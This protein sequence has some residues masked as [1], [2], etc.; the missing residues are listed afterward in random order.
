SDCYE[1]K[2]TAVIVINEAYSRGGSLASDGTNYGDY[3]W[4]ELYNNSD[5]EGDLGDFMLYDKEDKSEFVILPKGTK[6]APHGFLVVEVDVEGGFG[7]SRD[8]DQ[9]YLENAEGIMIDHIVFGS[10]TPDQAYARNPD[11]SE[12]FG[13]QKPT[14]GATNN[15]QT[16]IQIG[17]YTGLIINE[18]DGNG[19]FVELYN[20]S[21]NPISLEGVMLIKDESSTWWIGGDI[22][23]AAHGFYTIAQ[24]GGA[25]GANEYT[26]ASG[27]STKKIVKFELK[28]PYGA[29]IIDFF[30]RTL[31]GRNF[32]DNCTPD[33]AGPPS[34]SFSRC[35]NGTGEFGLAT[36]SCNSANPAIAAGAIVTN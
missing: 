24:S 20:N 6:I 14:R 16:P 12:T 23:I 29:L 18:V 9:V 22:S 17:D 13:I 19:K 31:E 15:T 8:G 2:P 26:G 27:I 21:S 32:G 35:P 33:Y 10:L 4:V 11:G 5:V 3:D 34:Y 25:S 36:P 30:A 7:L 1:P 28:S